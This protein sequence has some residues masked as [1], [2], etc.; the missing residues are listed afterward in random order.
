MKHHPF[1]VVL[2]IFMVKSTIIL[3]TIKLRYFQPYFMVSAFLTI[4]YGWFNHKNGKINNFF[5]V[6]KLRIGSFCSLNFRFP[7]SLSYFVQCP[8]ANRY[9][10]QNHRIHREKSKTTNEASYSEE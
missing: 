3:V 6:N 7:F 9:H 1:M 5:F 8:L 2:T 10:S 4:I